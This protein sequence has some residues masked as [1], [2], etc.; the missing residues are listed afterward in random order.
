MVY[1]HELTVRRWGSFVPLRCVDHSVSAELSSKG[2]L[3]FPPQMPIRWSEYWL[4]P[5]SLAVCPG[6]QSGRRWQLSAHG[7]ERGQPV[8]DSGTRNSA[9]G[10]WREWSGQ[11]EMLCLANIFLPLGKR[12][13]SKTLPVKVTGLGGKSC[14][15]PASPGYSDFI[16]IGHYQPRCQALW[17]TREQNSGMCWVVVSFPTVPSPELWVSALNVSRRVLLSILFQGSL[18]KVTTN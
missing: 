6:S 14:L 10:Q 3:C 2:N 5:W 18:P 16:L 1:P 7:Q 15:A 9:R 12:S 13:S 8:H 11:S 17:F 4:S